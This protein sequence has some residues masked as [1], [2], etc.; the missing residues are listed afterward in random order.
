M[1]EHERQTGIPQDR[2]APPDRTA[3]TGDVNRL[4]RRRRG[5]GRGEKKMVP[6]AHF[7]SYY[8]KPILNK[9]TWEARDIAGYLFLGGLAGGSS[10]LAMGAELTGRRKMA[11]VTKVGGLA[12]ILASLVALVHDLG[13]PERFVRML[14]VFKPSSPMSVGSW[15]L[16]TY[17]PLAGVAAATEIAGWFP[18]VGRAATVGAGVVGPAVA[19]YT[20]ALMSDTAV[21][22][23][24]DGYREMPFVFVGSAATAAGG[25]AVLASPAH[26]AG[27]ARRAL[28]LGAATE[29]AAGEVMSRRMG[30]SAEPLH[31][32]TAGR[33]MNAAKALSVFGAVVGG[34]G[35]RRSRTAAIIGGA[36][37]VAGSACTRFGIFHAGVASAEDPKYT[38]IP[39]RERLAQREGVP[40]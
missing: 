11:R 39:Q 9:P 38:V 36:A 5:R 35:G 12:A 40:G 25:L 19:S 27:P 1:S 32:G 15:I 2:S 8:G 30:L 28:I 22:T 7:E 17:G 13:R 6:D 34:V 31:Q 3:L 21:P 16:A 37:A 10:V 24:H 20:A 26:E 29:L 4:P 18:R 33:L 23:W 14:R